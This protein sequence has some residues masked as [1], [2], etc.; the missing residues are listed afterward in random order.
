MLDGIFKSSGGVQDAGL[1][2]KGTRGEAREALAGGDFR[3]PLAQGPEP[4]AVT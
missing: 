1:G 3:S 2:W 4:I